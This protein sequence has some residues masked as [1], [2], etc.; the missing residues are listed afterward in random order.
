[1]KKKKILKDYV[2]NDLRNESYVIDSNC[3]HLCK[4]KGF[5]TWTNIYIIPLIMSADL[6]IKNICCGGILSAV[7]LEG[8]GIKY[9]KVFNKCRWTKFYKN[10]GINIFPLCISE[11]LSAKIIIEHNL[12]EK[13]LYCEIDNGRPCHKCIKCFRKNLELE[14]FGY[15]HS[16]SYWQKYDKNIIKNKLSKRPLEWANLYIEIIKNN[17]TIPSYIKSE[18]KDIININSSFM[19]KLYA[20]SFDYFPNDIKNII[21]NQLT[22]YATIMNKNDEKN[23]KNINFEI[24]HLSNLNIYSKKKYYILLLLFVTLFIYCYKKIFYDK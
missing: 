5:T 9:R 1:M 16:K 14:Y 12:E 11:L 3:K 19:N 23:L 13:V 17:K 22:K 24:E 2:E 15:K 8:N 21:I 18:I 6:D 10:I 4:P 20:K 7:I